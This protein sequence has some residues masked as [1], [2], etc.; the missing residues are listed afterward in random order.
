MSEPRPTALFADDL[1]AR[2]DPGPGHPESP[3]RLAV[4]R[5]RLASEPLGPRAPSIRFEKRTATPVS[6]SVVP[7]VVKNFLSSAG[8]ASAFCSLV[9]SAA[10]EPS[11]CTDTP[12]SD[13]RWNTEDIVDVVLTIARSW[14]WKPMMDGSPSSGPSLRAVPA[15]GGVLPSYLVALW[16]FAFSAV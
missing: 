6:V 11:D 16:M 14:F 2:H 8:L 3:S 9:L 5:S 13:S 7:T 15:A 10:S 1:L 12:M 4:I